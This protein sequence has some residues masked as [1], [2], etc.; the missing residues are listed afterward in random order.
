[1]TASA[2][3]LLQ[4][5]EGWYRDQCDGEWEHSYGVAI[6]TLDNPGWSV[7][8]DLAGT[9]LANTRA[10]EERDDG[11]DGPGW[12]RMWM[13]VEAATFNGVGGP[14][15]LS[16]ILERFRRLADGQGDDQQ[17]VRFSRSPSKQPSRAAAPP[18]WVPPYAD[19]PS[20]A[21]AWM[22]AA[23]VGGDLV[24]WWDCEESGERY[25]WFAARFLGHQL[26]IGAGGE[27]ES[28]ASFVSLVFEREPREVDDPETFAPGS[29]VRSW[30]HGLFPLCPEEW[31]A[32]RLAELLERTVAALHEQDLDRRQAVLGHAA[33]AQ[34]TVRYPAMRWEVMRA[35]A[36]LADRSHQERVWGL[37]HTSPWG[38]NTLGDVI[39]ELF[40]GS[41]V[42]PNPAAA[43][44]WTLLPGDEVAY[45]E[46]LGAVFEPLI[47]RLLGAPN[48]VYLE[49]PEWPEIAEL[50][51][52]ALAAM[53]RGPGPDALSTSEPPSG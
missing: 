25:A 21:F 26:A 18:E 17:P 7:K 44:G 37:G 48:Q 42:L 22:A 23:L 53:I 27:P 14:A 33:S 15:A 13:D 31:P 16:V 2:D 1:M 39:G 6:G 9:A 51:G 46:R 30:G 40:D 50:A 41:E 19:D 28:E 34:A 29:P 8:I 3:D 24:V 47:S 45:L 32:V 38:V 11:H 4:W 36:Y 43:V 5:L 10:F 49:A 20:P 52:L 35:L 12:F